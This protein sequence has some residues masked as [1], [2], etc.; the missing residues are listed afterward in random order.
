V[1]RRLRWAQSRLR[2]P[3]V[4]Q[5]SFFGGERLVLIVFHDG[6]RA[7][8]AGDVHLPDLPSDKVQSLFLARCHGHD[9]GFPVPGSS[10]PGPYD[11]VPKSDPHAIC[12]TRRPPDVPLRGSEQP[13]LAPLFC[14]PASARWAHSGHP[15]EVPPGAALSG[16]E[17]L[18]V[19]CACACAW[20]WPECRSARRRGVDAA[21][22]RRSSI[23]IR[24]VRTRDGVVNIRSMSPMGMGVCTDPVSL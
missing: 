22:E 15:V 2:S 18:G 10:E 8:T 11:S 17:P 23:E 3:C 4:Q 9:R 24:P 6:P 5:Y 1:L 21:V 12:A 14:A 13:G 20:S 16:E 7:P 19:A